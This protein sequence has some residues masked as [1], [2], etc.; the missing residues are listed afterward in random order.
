MPDPVTASIITGGATLGASFLDR[1]SKEESAEAAERQKEKS[2]EFIRKNINRAR[3]DLFKLFPEIQ[4]TQREGLQAGMDLYQQSIPTQL[5]TF[6][7]GNVKAQEQ[8]QGG[9]QQRQNAILGNPIDMSQIQP[10]F[11][12]GLG[13]LRMPEAPQIS[14]I[15]PGDFQGPQQQGEQPP[16]MQS[17]AIQEPIERR[18]EEPYRRRLPSGLQVPSF[19]S[20]ES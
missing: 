4:D 16:N 19:N 17:P 9:L 15:N 6:R 10:Q 2:R 7:R 12:G 13:D 5:Q 8:L 11:V 20:G 3:G 14:R 1:E 18:L